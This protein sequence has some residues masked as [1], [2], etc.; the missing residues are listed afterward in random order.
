MPHAGLDQLDDLV[1]EARAAGLDLTLE[2]EPP[3]EPLPSAVDS[4]AY[5]I[6]QESIT[7]VIR[8]TGPTRVTVAVSAGIDHLEIR[9]TDRGRRRPAL[10]GASVSGP[11]SNGAGSRAGTGGQAGTGPGR[12][13]LGMRERCQLLGGD[14]GA[15]PTA[16][17][18]FE[19]T[20]RLPLA[21]TESRL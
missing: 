1:A 6:L 5:R 18:G 20:A 13:I 14:F 9:V 11:S 7:N 19:V 16:E 12:G 2:V 10:L 17:G 3:A 8:H 21:P 4:A 15:W